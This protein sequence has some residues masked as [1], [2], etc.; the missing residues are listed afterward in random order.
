MR[1]QNLFMQLFDIIVHCVP[2]KLGKTNFVCRTQQ[3]E[4]WI[5]GNWLENGLLSLIICSNGACGSLFQRLRK[6]VF[7]KNMQNAIISQF[8]TALEYCCL[9]QFC[10]IL[11][12]F[13]PNMIHEI[14]DKLTK[15]LTGI[16]NFSCILQ[17]K[18]LM[19]V[20]NK[21]QGSIF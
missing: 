5:I 21:F 9:C 6:K 1:P 16:S 12:T 20:L 10:V 8:R 14:N 17:S 15:Y 2:R 11:T 13:M 18:P 4:I 7:S 3:I 19:R